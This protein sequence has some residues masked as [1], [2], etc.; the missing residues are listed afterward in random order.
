MQKLSRSAIRTLRR[1]VGGRSL[2]RD[3]DGVVI[4]AFVRPRRRASP[5]AEKVGPGSRAFA[6][7]VKASMASFGRSWANTDIPRMRNANGS[8]GFIGTRCFVL[9]LHDA[10]LRL[11]FG[12]IAEV[13][14]EEPEVVRK[15]VR[16]GRSLTTSAIVSRALP[17][18]RS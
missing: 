3:A 8:F 17:K 1:H 14:V 13:K 9:L 10:G 16:F 2:L 11:G 12:E 4:P 18:S 15:S 7:L 5:D 6:A